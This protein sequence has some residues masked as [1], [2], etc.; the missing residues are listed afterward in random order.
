MANQMLVQLNKIASRIQGCLRVTIKWALH[1][2]KIQTAVIAASRMQPLR[3]AHGHVGDMFNLLHPT[4][5]IT[6]VHAKRI[7][8]CFSQFLSSTYHLKLPFLY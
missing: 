6:A 1:H 4:T 5:Y 8:T 2:V 3:A 7:W